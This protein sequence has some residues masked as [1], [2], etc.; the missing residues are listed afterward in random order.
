MD[1]AELIELRDKLVRARLSG[2][3]SIR[4]Q[5][6]ETLEYK[7]DA[8]MRAAIDS[9]EF[10]IGRLTSARPHTIIFKT[11]KGLDQ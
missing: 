8:E 9:I 10:E 2:V 7:S 11:S 1:V 3:R 4:D 6:G 5:N